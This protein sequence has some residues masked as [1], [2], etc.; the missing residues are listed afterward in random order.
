MW[1]P[2]DPQSRPPPGGVNRIDPPPRRF[3]EEPPP[4][5]VPAAPVTPPPSDNIQP[6]TSS[7]PPLF[8]TTPPDIPLLPSP[9]AQEI[10]LGEF[11]KIVT[12]WVL[13]SKKISQASQEA[14]NRLSVNLHLQR[15]STA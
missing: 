13:E 12:A 11:L 10:S 4:A 7:P 2:L 15:I 9:S 5:T 8:L 3:L 6:S 1:M 14:D